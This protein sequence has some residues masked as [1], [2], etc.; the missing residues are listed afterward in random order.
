MGTQKRV[1]KRGTLAIS[2]MERHSLERLNEKENEDAEFVDR[3][4]SHSEGFHGD[5]HSRSPAPEVYD[6]SRG[7][8]KHSH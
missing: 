2:T 6:P 5:A 8:F 7:V 1:E 3:H 4:V